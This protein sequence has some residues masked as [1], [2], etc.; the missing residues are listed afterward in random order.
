MGYA[1]KEGKKALESPN[2]MPEEIAKDT[3]PISDF[4]LPKTHLDTVTKLIRPTHI[5]K[6]D[7]AHHFG[8]I[9]KET[10]IRLQLK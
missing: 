6:T 7:G 8:R 1:K 2:M 5:W 4:H 10:I 3:Q 9:R